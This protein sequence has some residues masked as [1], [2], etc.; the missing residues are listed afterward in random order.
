MSKFMAK[1]T[2]KPITGGQAA[3]EAMRQ[4]NPGVVAVYPITPQTPI[5]EQFAKFCADGEVD[6]EIVNV[7][8]EHSAL[9]TAIGG[10]AAGVRAMTATA[11]QGLALMHEILHIASGMR[12]PIVMNVVSRALSSPIN[13][14]CD[15]S[16]VM[17]ARDA[18]WI[19]IFSENPQEV[20]DHNLLAIKL[21]EH[22]DVLLP[23]MVIQD[24][25]ITS[26][27]VERVEVLL[28]ENVQRF[29][30]TY[31]HP[32]K[33]LTY[34]D[35]ITLGPTALPNWQMDIKEQ[36]MN[37]MGKAAEHY[38]QVT[39]KL[40]ELTGRYYSPTESYNLEQASTVLVALGSTTGTIRTLLKA[41][42][43]PA[44][45]LL[46]IRLFRPFPYEEVKDKLGKSERIIVLDKTPV[47][48][49]APPLLTEIKNAVYDLDKRPKVESIIYG[50]GGR[51]IDTEDIQQ[52]LK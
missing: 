10:Q 41:M 27:C 48:G 45:G 43:D 11:S 18:G 26:H 46:K 16:D 47:F 12:M 24:G 9:S 30:G 40:S 21:A 22:P 17:N 49:A 29:T 35:P 3:A 1:K 20:Y 42:N 44:I 2:T 15:H 8:S 5:I 32:I 50:L 38:L 13:I 51:D 28:D 4:I 31:E 33:L 19:Q 39:E 7:E 37:A 23:A 34:S 36:Q 52:M 6:T 14:H 25:F